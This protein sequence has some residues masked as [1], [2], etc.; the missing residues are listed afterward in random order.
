MMLTTLKLKIKIDSDEIL[1][2]DS[3]FTWSRGW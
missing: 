2:P 1:R 3:E